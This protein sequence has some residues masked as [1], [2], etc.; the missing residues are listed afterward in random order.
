MLLVGSNAFMVASTHKEGFAQEQI[1]GVVTDRLRYV[2]IVNEVLAR[3]LSQYGYRH[4]T[5][6][7]LCAACRLPCQQH[8]S[9]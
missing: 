7:C 4:V 5:F 6:G 9:A 2:V 1:L 8:I 3:Y